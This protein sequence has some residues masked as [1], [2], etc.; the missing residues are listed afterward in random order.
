ME[1]LHKVL[2]KYVPLSHPTSIRYKNNMSYIKSTLKCK[3]CGYEMNVATGT[4]GTG[5]PEK[6]PQCGY[7]REQF[8]TISQDWVA[9]NEVSNK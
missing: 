1:L 4:F 3:H 2:V 9:N 7:L 8:K 5:I 6:C